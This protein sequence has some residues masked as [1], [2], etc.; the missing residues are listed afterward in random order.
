MSDYEGPI[1]FTL[2]SAE[3]K[4]KLRQQAKDRV[5]ADQ[6]KAAQKAYFDKMLDEERRA[7][8][9]EEEEVEFAIDLPMFAKHVMINGVQY[10]H[11]GVYT[12][13]RA[14]FDTIADIIAQAWRHDDAV[15]EEEVRDRN[16]RSF[17]TT[18]RNGAVMNMPSINRGAVRI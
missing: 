6:I 15:L 12:T 3:E 14:R 16:R 9:P 2:L 18:V 8:D 5:R 1:D 13:T 11:G 7:L 10:L 17:G 4:A